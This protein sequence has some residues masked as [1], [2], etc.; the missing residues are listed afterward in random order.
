MTATNRS[1]ARVPSDFYPTPDG[2]S[3]PLM[4][5]LV[6]QRMLRSGMTVIDPA[7]GAGALLA[8]AQ[9]V[10][11]GVRTVGYEL[12]DVQA[13]PGTWAW[14]SG[15]D[16]LTVEA[17]DQWDKACII[18]NPPFSL[19]RPFVERFVPMVRW[20]AWLLRLNWLGS[21]GRVDLFRAMPPAWV[22]VLPKRPSFVGGHTDACEYAWFV[23]DRDC[24]TSRPWIDWLVTSG[25]T[26]DEG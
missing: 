6:A 3:V 2:A 23:W 11:P 21:R 14:R 8:A 12:R 1:A 19:A 20:S 9:R 16:A 7:A 15:V 18:A 22:L 25:R 17:G 5:W 26:D 24:G 10:V 13:P 4:R